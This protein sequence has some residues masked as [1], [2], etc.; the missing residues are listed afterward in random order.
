MES[1]LNY[2]V[3]R[4]LRFGNSEAKICGLRRAL[5]ADA[6][7]D[8]ADPGD[9]LVK[10]KKTNTG[11]SVK[12][13]HVDDIWCQ[14]VQLR[15]TG[16]PEKWEEGQGCV[17]VKTRSIKG[18]DSATTCVGLDTNSDGGTGT[19]N[20]SDILCVSAVASATFPKARDQDVS[21]DGWW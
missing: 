21:D 7:K 11:L 17:H 18:R 19:T 3:A 20:C 2:E 8:L 16:S 1:V 12:D 10:R 15:S 9:V 6:V 13:E 4:P 14:D 5:F